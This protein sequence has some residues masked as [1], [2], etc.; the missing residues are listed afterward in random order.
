MNALI[1]FMSEVAGRIEFHIKA[2]LLTS[3]REANLVR[4]L[5]I[6]E[7]AAKDMEHHFRAENSRLVA[8]VTEAYRITELAGPSDVL[9]AH[10]RAELLAALPSL[11]K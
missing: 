11:D 4:L 6:Q 7:G 5:A 8:R 10:A 3:E 1:K 2:P 9:L